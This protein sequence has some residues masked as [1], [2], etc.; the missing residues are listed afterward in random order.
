[1]IDY[2]DEVRSERFFYVDSLKADYMVHLG[3]RIPSD[4]SL[5]LEGKQVRL[6]HI[7]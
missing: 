5:I 7:Y 3:K 6:N 2:N 4:F 1:M